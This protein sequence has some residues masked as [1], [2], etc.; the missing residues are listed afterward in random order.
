MRKN[1]A[2]SSDIKSVKSEHITFQEKNGL[3]VQN[4]SP[5]KKLAPLRRKSISDKKSSTDQAYNNLEREI[6][7]LQI[8]HANRN[9]KIEI[10]QKKL[11]DLIIDPKLTL[12]A[13]RRKSFDRISQIGKLDP[14]KID[15]TPN[16]SSTPNKLDIAEETQVLQL[17]NFQF[18]NLK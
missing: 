18:K 6:Q 15:M 7:Q 3:H 9:L 11:E 17:K 14:K 16:R 5:K 10:N 13:S 8:Q 2:Q 1:E 4:K 12:E